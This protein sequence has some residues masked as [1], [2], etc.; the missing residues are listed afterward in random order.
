MTQSHPS[1]KSRTNNRYFLSEKYSHSAII[2]LFLFTLIIIPSQA[3]AATKILEVNEGDFVRLVPK[4]IDADL[5][6]ITYSFSKP[7][8]A[9]GEWQ[10]TYNDE[11]E[12]SITITASD[13][14]EKTTK[15]VLLRVLHKNQAPI[16][17]Q[18]KINTSETKTIDLK[19]VVNDPDNDTLEY[20]FPQPFNNNGIYT[21]NYS[22]AGDRIVKFN[23]TDG[24]FTVPARIAIHIEDVNQPPS[25]IDIFPKGSAINEKEGNPIN[26]HVS[27][28]DENPEKLTILW[29][30]DNKSISDKMN[31]TY[32]IGYEEA[33]NHTLKFTASDGFN[34]TEKEWNVTVENTNRAPIIAYSTIDAEEGDKII[35]DLPK[36]DED[37]Q[38]I[39]YTF[40]G[41]FSSIG[42]WQTTYDDAG[43]HNATITASDGEL[44]TSKTIN[45]TIRD[46]DRAPILTLPPI[47]YA[48]EG[49]QLNWS[50]ET[51]DPDGDNVS[52]NFTN[53]PPSASF[54]N[55]TKTLLWTPS[56]DELH[57]RGGII[58]DILNT[59]RLEQYFTAS[60]TIEVQ[61][62]SCGKRWCSRGTVPIK[63]YDQNRAPIINSSQ[64]FT[65]KETQTIT[66][67]PTAF[68]PDGDIIHYYYSDPVDHNKWTPSIND[69]G[70]KTIYVTASDGKSQYTQPIN[71]TVEKLDQAPK[72]ILPGDEFTILEGQEISF[73]VSASD[74]DGD[75]VTLRIED[76]PPGASFRDGIFNWTPSYDIVENKTDNF[77]N[78][79]ASMS[80]ITTR[81]FSTE[82]R[83]YFMR[84]AGSDGEIEA[85]HPVKITVKNSNRAPIIVDTTQSTTVAKLGEPVRF[86]I[87]ANDPD[88]D[89]LHYSWYTALTEPRIHQTTTLERIFKSPGNK[90]VSVTIGD[91]RDS[92]KHTFEVKVINEPYF[93]PA[94]PIPTYKVFVIEHK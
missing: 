49:I 18:N 69:Q 64:S 26:F 88:Q 84:F 47:L 86:E 93:V 43:I 66:F 20:N 12:Y 48:T 30:W 59:L 17:I 23:V 60:K 54:N 1:S 51:N 56:Y 29:M 4:A 82:S 61:V 34:S 19:L 79:L 78:N 8:D 85:I 7:I 57:R 91:G 87:E 11:G 55:K 33:G 25:I 2:L 42:E 31:G 13:G 83:T 35:L 37:N 6:K 40:S 68:D 90:E 9:K 65:V 5:D 36:A 10:T 73:Q 28:S 45:I 27:M 38:T 52:I 24:E 62:E 92:I 32:T 67:E 39:N 44:T 74:A 71:I 77:R 46:V 21:T 89:K 14:K 72:L 50:I 16:I 80:N 22:D 70:T 58:S 41:P 76:L 81:R 3:F 53:L 63:I 75:N 15:T 94:P